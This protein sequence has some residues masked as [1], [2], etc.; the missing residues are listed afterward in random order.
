MIAY[1]LLGLLSLWF[2]RRDSRLL[3]LTLVV[4]G[5]FFL[6]VPRTSQAVFYGT[7]IAVEVI[8]AI[9]ALVLRTRASA[10]V[11][12][13]CAVM[14]ISHIMA[15]MIDGHSATSVYKPIMFAAEY[16]QM[17]VCLLAAQ[18]VASRLKNHE[19]PLA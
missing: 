17:L 10:L 6:D 18:P 1:G 12:E 19:S 7:C 9:T 5:S 15:W 13:L 14:V 11:A 3:L 2:N 8:V 16:S 4:G